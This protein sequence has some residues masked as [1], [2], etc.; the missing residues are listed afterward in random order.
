MNT[1]LKILVA[2][3]KPSYLLKN[4]IFIP[5]HVGRAV[6][7]SASKDG[8]NNSS[9]LQWLLKNTIGDDTGD[10]I[11]QKN[12]EYCECT[13]LYWAWK[14]YDKL[15][16][17]DYIGFMQYRRHFILN[18]DIFK[19]KK[20][21]NYEL[22]YATRKIDYPG[23]NYLH[24]LGIDK[25][26]L[27]R[28][29]KNCGGVFTNPCDLSLVGM[30]SQ[31]DDY[32]KKIP[33]TNVADFDMMIDVVTKMHPAMADYIRERAEQPLKS[34][35]QMWILP[36]KIFFEYMNFLFPVLFECEKNI[37]T[38]SYNINGKRTMGYLAE[39]LY[40]YFM[41][42]YKETYKLKSVN[43]C[44]INILIENYNINI[45]NTIELYFL[46][47]YNKIKFIIFNKESMRSTYKKYKLILKAKSKKDKYT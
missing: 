8:Y 21:D 25:E 46:Y 3:H 32:M 7:S 10:N 34:C 39:L 4:D 28:F 47:L 1:S 17:P 37:D 42:F 15:G 31:R 29:L 9:D 40:D 44:M 2:Y 14:N 27:Y 12:R 45:H 6:A 43:V 11:S 35:F 16:N 20:L 24:F 5:I 26:N 23:N 19:E 22:A 41:N 30:K 33:G 36:K 13:A 38:S 18:E